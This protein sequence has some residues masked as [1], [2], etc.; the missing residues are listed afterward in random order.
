MSSNRSKRPTRKTPISTNSRARKR[1]R[2][3]KDPVD[4]QEPS[5]YRSGLSRNC[6]VQ[7]FRNR[8][9]IA[10]RWI[11]FPWFNENG[12]DFK[13]IFDFHG[14]SVLVNLK[15]EVFTYLVK[16]TYANF[17]YTVTEDASSLINGKHLDLFVSSLKSLASAPNY[18]KF[19]DSY[20]CSGMSEVEPID[21]PRV[22]FWIT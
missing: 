21:I 7:Y 19:F 20:G 9:V 2:S 22:F 1:G 14:W 4:V 16:L 3:N 6:F 5:I 10:R 11:D 12:F 8:K 15:V 17:A 18:G 13:E